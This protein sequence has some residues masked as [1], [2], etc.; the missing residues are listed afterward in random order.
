MASLSILI[1]KHRTIAFSLIALALTMKALIPAGFMLGTQDKVLTVLVC[2]DA[3]GQHLTK[4]I[5]I[6][7]SGKPQST[8]KQGESCPFASLST[9]L[10]GTADVPFIALAIAFML[11]LGFAPVRI[12]TLGG[13][14]YIRPPLRGPPSLI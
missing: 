5:S 6:P 14:T 11:L 13:F 7:V 12:P 8:A 10:L 4:S 2:A 9:A 1:R 3:T